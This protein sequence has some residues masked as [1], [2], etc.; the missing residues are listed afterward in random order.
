MGC[1]ESLLDRIKSYLRERGLPLKASYLL[2]EVDLDEVRR[3]LPKTLVVRMQS[4]EYAHYRWRINEDGNLHFD[5]LSSH[6]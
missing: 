5:C 2:D 3:T 4:K 1:S 6:W